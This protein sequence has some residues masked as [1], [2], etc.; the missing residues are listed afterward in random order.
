VSPYAALLL[1]RLVSSGDS[2]RP[3]A[4]ASFVLTLPDLGCL[5]LPK[6]MKL[7]GGMEVRG[8]FS[9]SGAGTKWVPK[10]KVS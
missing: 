10:E 5:R 7:L 9:L 8:T 4:P 6:H 1:V 3:P 2:S